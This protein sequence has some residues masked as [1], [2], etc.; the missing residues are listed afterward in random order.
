M[1]QL[2]E[3]SII[4]HYSRSSATTT[5]SAKLSDETTDC[6]PSRSAASAIPPSAARTRI[7]PS[8]LKSFAARWRISWSQIFLSGSQSRLKL[9]S[10]RRDCQW[11]R[12][13]ICENVNMKVNWITKGSI[14]GLCVHF[15]RLNIFKNYYFWLEDWSQSSISCNNVKNYKFDRNK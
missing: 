13:R 4:G 5:S 10:D 1:E 9:S 6:H 8:R 12:L 2:L 7:P 15:D 14:E 3:G 11:G